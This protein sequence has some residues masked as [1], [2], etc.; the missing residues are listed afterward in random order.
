MIS[1]EEE[2]ARW[3][4]GVLGVHTPRALL[5]AVFYMNG[6]VLCLRGGQE[7]KNLKNL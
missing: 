1:H 4:A 7:H 2:R 5:N 6:K 3:T